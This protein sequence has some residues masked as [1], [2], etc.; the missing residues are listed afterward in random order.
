MLHLHRKI[1][2]RADFENRGAPR[3]QIA[4]EISSGDSGVFLFAPFLAKQ[5]S[6]DNVHDLQ[7]GSL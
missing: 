4:M 6:H 5:T 7:M 2:A 1:I 3:I